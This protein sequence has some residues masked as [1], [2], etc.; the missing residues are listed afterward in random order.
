MDIWST[1]LNKQSLITL[2]TDDGSARR[3]AVLHVQ[4]IKGSHSGAAICQ[5]IEAMGNG[6]IENI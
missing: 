2:T 1:S 5:M 6:Y 3:S 4:R